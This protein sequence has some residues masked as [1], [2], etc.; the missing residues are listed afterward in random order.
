MRPI[1]N[2]ATVTH[3]T[4]AELRDFAKSHHEREFALIDVRQSDE[5]LEGHIPGA[6][7]MPLQELESYTDKLRQLADRCLIFYCRGGARSARAATWVSQVLKLPHVCDLI[8]GMKGWSGQALVDFPRLTSFAL[9]GSVEELLRRALDLEKGTHRLYAH[10]AAE[11]PSV[12]I[13]EFFSHLIDA[14]LAHGEA[15]HGLLMEVVP[16]EQPS[17][18]AAFAALPGSIVENGMSMDLVVT[19]ARELGPRG[20]MALLELALEIELGAYELYK[21]LATSVSS[22]MAQRTL[23]ELAQQ[24]K[25]H[26]EWV[27]RAISKLA[28]GMG[29][30]TA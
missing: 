8:G 3:I 28:K 30:V 10:I 24:E 16:H 12:E 7:L 14:E 19:R 1:A 26:A 6:L 27:L 11:Y 5:Y 4:S 9:D 22:A 20:E 13:A 23:A 15:V 18:E 29:P 2:S 21:T 25:E 17:F